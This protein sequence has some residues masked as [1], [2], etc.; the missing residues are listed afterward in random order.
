M[1]HGLV[2]ICRYA[3]REQLSYLSI[4]IL[5]VQTLFLIIGY[6]VRPILHQQDNFEQV[7]K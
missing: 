7:W 2:D 5:S 3:S 1:H 6:D 4:A